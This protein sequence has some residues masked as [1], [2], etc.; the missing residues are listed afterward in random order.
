MGIQIAD[1]RQKVINKHLWS[2]LRNKQT[3]VFDSYRVYQNFIMWILS[4]FRII[5]SSYRLERFENSG[6]FLL[7]RQKYFDLNL[8]SPYIAL[9]NTK[10]RSI[11]FI[12]RLYRNKF[13]RC[14][15]LLS[16]SIHVR[17]CPPFVIR[18]NSC[19]CGEEFDCLLNW[20]LFTEL[21]W[22]SQLSIDWQFIS[23]IVYSTTDLVRD[24]TL[25]L[26]SRR[27]LIQSL[28]VFV[29]YSIRCKLFY[30]YY[31]DNL[32]LNFVNEG[33]VYRVKSPQ[34]SRHS[35]WDGT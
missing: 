27:N 25:N 15:S 14:K 21:Y 31:F 13:G 9:K 24:L 19:A 29:G 32:R 4:F 34:Y 30:C 3:G 26:L 28:R 33:R 11:L 22:L 17:T 2:I 18:M 10:L 12:S 1:E 35:E 6:I 5:Y 23:S 8:Y 7:N 20:A 16:T